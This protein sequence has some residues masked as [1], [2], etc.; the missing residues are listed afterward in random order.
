MLCGDRDET[1]HYIISERIKL[2][3]NVYKARHD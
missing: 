1:I 3:Q 2:A